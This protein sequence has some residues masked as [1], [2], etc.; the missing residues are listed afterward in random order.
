MLILDTSVL[1]EEEKYN[2]KILHILKEL[3]SRFP[4]RAYITAPTYTEFIF[5]Y[6]EQTSAKQDKAIQF[7]SEYRL[8]NTT[9]NSSRILAKLIYRLQKLGK[10]IPIFDALI[11]SIVIDND[12]ILITTDEH[13]KNIEGLNL[14]V[15]D[16]VYNTKYF[17]DT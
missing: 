16:K 7:L 9:K 14:I 5:G 13:Y 2:P 6:M 15:I 12:G 17:I 3:H 8:L 11:A 1:I 4:G 10:M